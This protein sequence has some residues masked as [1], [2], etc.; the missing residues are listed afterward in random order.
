MFSVFLSTP[1]KKETH[2]LMS[3]LKYAFLKNERK[4]NL[5]FLLSCLRTSYVSVSDLLKLCKMHNLD[6]EV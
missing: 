5:D 4:T 1:F 3:M 2:F 6:G